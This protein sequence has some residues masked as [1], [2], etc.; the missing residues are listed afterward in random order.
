MTPEQRI[1]KHEATISAIR[2]D[3]E[4]LK[5]TSFTIGDSTTEA[6]IKREAEHISMY[7]SFIAKLKVQR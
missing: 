3:I 1:K 2:E 4:W 5:A 7:E 6:L